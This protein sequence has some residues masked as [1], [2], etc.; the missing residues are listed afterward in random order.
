LRKNTTTSGWSSPS[1]GEGHVTG[2]PLL[3]KMH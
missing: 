2:L 3:V 1:Q